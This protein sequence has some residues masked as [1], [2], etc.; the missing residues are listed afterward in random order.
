MLETSF[1]YLLGPDISGIL[2]FNNLKSFTNSLVILKQDE[3]TKTA[4]T[5][6]KTSG[7][8]KE[9][10]GEDGDDDK[11]DDNDGEHDGDNDRT[12]VLAGPLSHECRLHENVDLWW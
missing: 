7:E 1:V 12:L 8:D 2:S 10:E 9:D 3:Q 4:K 11:E 6:T 5:A